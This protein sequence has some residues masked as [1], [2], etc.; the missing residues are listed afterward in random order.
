MPTE[1]RIFK[2]LVFGM[3][4]SAPDQAMRFAVEVARLLNLDLLGMFLEDTS[5]QDLATIPFAREFRSLGGGWHPIDVKRLS[6][7]LELAARTAQRAFTEAAKRLST[8]WRFEVARGPMAST[9]TAVLQT[10]DIVM[11]G[12]PGG[13]GERFSQQFSWL[14]QA[15]F[16]SAA[17]VM[18]VPSQILRTKGPVVAIA[19]TTDDPSIVAAAGIA[20]AADEELFVIDLCKNAIDE[21]Q[22]RALAAAEGLVV[23]H[24]I[25]SRTTSI[26]VALVEQALRPLQGRLVVMT[27]GAFDDELVLLIAA[28]QRVPVLVIEPV[29]TTAKSRPRSTNDR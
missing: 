21:V 14:I 29:V 17:A 22:I 24:V 20:R 10:S 19:A 13:I 28:E 8:Q 11:I 5:L 15:A 4:P 27:R 3:Q 7:E 2:R 1:S 18:V 12:E 25:G 9:I 16:R 23:K 26:N 6:D